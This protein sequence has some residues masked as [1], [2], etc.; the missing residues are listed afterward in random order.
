MSTAEECLDAGNNELAMG[1]L[2]KA[3]ALYRCAVE[4]DPAF[5]DGWQALSMAMLKLGRYVESIEAGLK[6]LELRPNDQM[7]YT[8]LSIAYAR[9][10]QIPEA[11][12]MA[13]KARI[14]SWGGKAVPGAGT[15]GLSGHG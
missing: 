4:H 11:E 8:S 1:E 15:G 13:A 12:A 10:H 9:N 5:F 7:A 6:S 2:E 3:A 14:I